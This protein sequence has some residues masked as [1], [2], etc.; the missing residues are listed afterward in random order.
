MVKTALDKG[1]TGKDLSKLSFDE[2][3]LLF[4]NIE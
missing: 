4:N 3:T 2:L 1:V